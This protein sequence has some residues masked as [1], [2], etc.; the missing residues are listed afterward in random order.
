RDEEGCLDL[1]RMRE[2]GIAAG[3]FAIFV[4]AHDGA[5]PDPRALVVPTED[6]YEVPVEPPLPFE[7]AARVA[8]ELAT[9]ASRDLDLVRTVPE[10]ER[11]VGGG[12]GPGAIL[13]LEGAEPVEPGLGNLEDWVERGLRSIGI[14]WSRPNAFGRGVPFRFPGT[15][16]SGPG[17]TPAGR[18]LVRACNELGVMLD[19]AH[20]NLAGFR[21]VAKLS[22]RPLVWTH[23]GVHARC[24]IPRSLLDEELDAI[25]DSGGVAGIVFDSVMTHPTGELVDDAPLGQILDHVEYVAERIGVEHVALGSD[26]DGAHPPRALSDATKVQALL[27]A[28]RA[29][30]WA[31]DELRA[32]GHRN[33]LRVLAD[34]WL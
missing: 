11:C 14:V 16:D 22:D 24:P 33:W 32:L 34:T 20:L 30:G 5:A 12:P 26:F 8:D 19:L 31:D 17:L 7:R 10:L 4:P 23:G 1:P 13:H 15:P 27:E 29:R 28:L 2:G 6:G 3:F 9:I 18:E 25:R 21:D